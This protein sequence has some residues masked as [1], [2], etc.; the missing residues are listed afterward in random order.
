VMDYLARLKAKLADAAKSGDEKTQKPN[1][2][3]P[4]KRS[5]GAFEAFDSNSRAHIPENE[6]TPHAAPGSSAS[7]PSAPMAFPPLYEATW[8]AM[9][10]QCPPGVRPGEGAIYDAA[11]LFGDWGLELARLGWTANDLLAAPRRA[12]TAGAALYGS[13]WARQWWRSGKQSLL[14]K[15]GGFMSDSRA[16]QAT[17]ESD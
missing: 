2:P 10:A 14:R 7:R 15:T 5:K 9:L 16:A 11:L 6:P 4:S 12:T 3:L 1:I 8:R 17:M 13:S